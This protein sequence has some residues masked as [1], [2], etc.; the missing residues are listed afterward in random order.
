MAPILLY[1]NKLII[2]WFEIIDFYF[3]F[4]L[5]ARNVD[6]GDVEERKKLR[7]RLNCKNFRW[8]LENVYPESQMPLDYYYLGD[9]SIK[10][11]LFKFNIYI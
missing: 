2:K 5:G 1:S 10:N 7:K 3:Y 6:I 11:L 8:Y 4:L 9:V